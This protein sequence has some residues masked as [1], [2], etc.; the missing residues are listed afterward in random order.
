MIMDRARPYL[1]ND[2]ACWT[3]CSLEMSAA[4]LSLDIT[5]LSFPNPVR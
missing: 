4:L 2:F 3:E 1:E 5:T